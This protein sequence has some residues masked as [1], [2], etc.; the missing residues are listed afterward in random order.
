MS[1]LLQCVVQR[2]WFSDTL[3]RCFHLRKRDDSSDKEAVQRPVF[4]RSWDCSQIRKMKN[5]RKAGKKVTKWQ[6]SA[7]S[8]EE[9][10]ADFGK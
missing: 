5:R 10:V 2:F 6:H 1:M 3:S 4:T 9:R 7:Y 8:M